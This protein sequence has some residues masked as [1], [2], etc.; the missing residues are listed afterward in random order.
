VR[1]SGDAG[2]EADIVTVTELEADVAKGESDTLEFKKSTAERDTAMKTVCGMLNGSG[3]RV[4]IGVTEAGKV[5]GQEVSD[6]TLKD[7]AQAVVPF[8]PAAHVRQ[9]R[10]RLAD[11]KQVFVLQVEP[12]PLAPHTFQ[13]RPYRP[14]NS[15]TS[16]MPQSEYQRRLLERDHATLRWE[17]R[18][19]AGD[20]VLDLSEVQRTLTDAVAAGRLESSITD[21]RRALEKLG[22]VGSDRVTQAAVVGFA[23][24][25]FPLYPQ[26][27]LRLARFRGVTKTEFLDQ[28]QLTGHARATALH[29]P[30]FLGE[31]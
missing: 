29:R 17:N 30:Q 21:P 15:T 22:L 13:G 5:R 4:F 16:V 1:S 2:A 12:S 18:A 19:A 7:M 8:D 14:V 28:Q 31:L 9:D 3:G 27:A 20:F 25:P 26:C 23:V 11:G 24:E 10:V 6:A